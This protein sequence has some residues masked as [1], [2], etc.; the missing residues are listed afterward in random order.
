VP[1]AASQTKS[2]RL[3]LRSLRARNSHQSEP[4]VAELSPEPR[5][6]YMRC[7]GV[8]YLQRVT[9]SHSDLS[10]HN[11]Q[12]H[13]KPDVAERPGVTKRYASG[14]ICRRVCSRLG[15]RKYP[16]VRYGWLFY[17]PMAYLLWPR[18]V[19]HSRQPHSAP[20]DREMWGQSSGNDGRWFQ[21][22]QCGF[23]ADRGLNRS[24]E[25]DL[26]PRVW[27]GH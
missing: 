16:C 11:K 26:D 14:H 24:L 9:T 2:H 20:C 22:C 21:R 18:S 19:T 17:I 13:L 23:D 12:T 1:S 15:I 10:P 27:I 6:R 5:N 3:Q 25:S 7:A 4:S 8:C